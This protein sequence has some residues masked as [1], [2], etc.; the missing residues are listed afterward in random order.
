MAYE[1]QQAMD[2]VALQTSETSTSVRAEIPDDLTIFADRDG[3]RCVLRNL[4]HNALR[5][6]EGGR[7]ML[8][9]EATAGEAT[10]RVADDGVGF[11]PELGQKIFGKFYRL[12]DERHAGRSGTGLGL[13]LVRRLV[14]LD[15]GTVRA[16]S[17]GPGKGAVF[18][19]HWPLAP[20]E[21]A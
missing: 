4:L 17:D 14:E 6:A 20:H 1:V 13:Y 18:T 21:H 12:D 15:G 11:P 19:V 7:V 9:A 16:H 8:T 5:A 3:V 10:L 2:E